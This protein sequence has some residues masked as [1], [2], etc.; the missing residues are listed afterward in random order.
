MLP[1]FPFQRN[2]TGYV[3]Q[4]EYEMIKGVVIVTAT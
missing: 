2:Q 4:F 3:N 1:D